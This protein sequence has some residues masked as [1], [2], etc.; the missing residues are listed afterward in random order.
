M[1]REVGWFGWVGWE[2]GAGLIKN[3]LRKKRREVEEDLSLIY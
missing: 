1:K 2:P 3:R